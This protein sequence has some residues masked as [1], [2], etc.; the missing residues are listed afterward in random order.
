MQA[1]QLFGGPGAP[2]VI[3]NSGLV[4][5][6]TGSNTF[7]NSLTVSNASLTCD[8]LF[9]GGSGGVFDEHALEAAVVGFAHRRVHADVGGDSVITRCVMP[10]T[11]SRRSRSVA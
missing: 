11:R 1:F 7:G 10:R 5:I 2:A 3:I 9:V 8:T 6:G 4:D